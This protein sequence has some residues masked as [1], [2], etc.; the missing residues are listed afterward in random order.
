MALLHF[1]RRSLS[2]I[3]CLFQQQHRSTTSDQAVFRSRH[4]LSALEQGDWLTELDLL[5]LGEALQRSALSSGGYDDTVFDVMVAIADLLEAD[6]GWSAEQSEAW[7]D[8]MGLWE[9][10]F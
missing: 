6:H 9:E 8:R 10:E 4:A 7:L 5:H 2:L 3:A 1:F